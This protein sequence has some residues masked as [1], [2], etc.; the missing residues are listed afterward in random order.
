MSKMKSWSWGNGCK[1][2]NVK[3]KDIGFHYYKPARQDLKRKGRSL[4][5]TV[6][7]GDSLVKIG[8]NGTKINTIKKM[9][10]LAGEI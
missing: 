10:R 9:L 3:H 2:V 1:V 6:M 5:I 4:E 8:L 7:N